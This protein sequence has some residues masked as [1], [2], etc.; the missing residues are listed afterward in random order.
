MRALTGCQSDSRSARALGFRGFG[1]LSGGGMEGW[2]SELDAGRGSGLIAAGLVG[3]GARLL[4]FVQGDVVELGVLMS[5][6]MELGILVSWAS[7]PALGSRLPDFVHGDGME[8]GVLMSRAS[9]PN[10]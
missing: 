9:M 4:D 10:S 8:L 6:A 7:I 3:L 5:G 2:L 1:L